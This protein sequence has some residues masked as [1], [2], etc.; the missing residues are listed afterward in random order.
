MELITAKVLF[1]MI[2]ELLAE[3]RQAAFTVDNNWWVCDNR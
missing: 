3:G 2:E 1:P